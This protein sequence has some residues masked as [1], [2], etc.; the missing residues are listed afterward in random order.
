MNTFHTLSIS[1]VKQ[2]TPNAVSISFDIPE[3]LQ[4]IF[5]FKSGQYITIKHSVNGNE[6]RRAYSICTTPKSGNVKVGIKKV[7]GG[8]FSEF[9]ITQLKVGDHLVTA[10][11]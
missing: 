1:E 10:V 2:E 11:S 3:N 9:A 4:T 7:T 8:L 5:T 6:I